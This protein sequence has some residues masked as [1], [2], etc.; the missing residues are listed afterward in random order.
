MDDDPLVLDIVVLTLRELGHDAVGAASA[1]EA[2]ASLAA[3]PFDLVLTDCAMP[4]G[5]TEQG[6]ALADYAAARGIAAVLM[7]GNPAWLRSLAA[8]DLSRY[9]IL[10]KPF[11]QAD[12]AA[13]IEEALRR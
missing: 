4:G 2:R 10:R 11:R 8:G 13:I 9:P 3:A 5:P 7:S 1:A 12:L 6:E